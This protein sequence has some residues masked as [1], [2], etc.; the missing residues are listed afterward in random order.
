M[1]P[2]TKV[3]ERPCRCLT[4]GQS[5]GLTGGSPMARSLL[6]LA[7]TLSMTGCG[8]ADTGAAAAAA[9]A[10]DRPSRRGRLAANRSVG[11]GMRAS[12]SA[13]SLPTLGPNRV[14]RLLL[15]AGPQPRAAVGHRPIRYHAGVSVWPK[16]A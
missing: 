10:D 11:A 3:S 4:H 14:T 7:L 9:A 16:P 15:A 5:F 13:R 8:V 2:V 1:H 12:R 6:L